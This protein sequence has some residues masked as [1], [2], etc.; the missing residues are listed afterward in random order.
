MGK[1]VELFKKGYKYCGKTLECIGVSSGQTIEKILENINTKVCTCC[2]KGLKYSENFKG[3]NVAEEPD[4]LDVNGGLSPYCSSDIT[5]TIVEPGTYH[6]IFQA[7]FNIAGMSV[8][9]IAF[10][11][12]GQLLYINNPE[13]RC[14]FVPSGVDP[15]IMLPITIRQDNIALAAGDVLS[16]CST[17]L[18]TSGNNG[19][20]AVYKD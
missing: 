14:Q 12:N 8:E 9:N 20:F 2:S 5:F 18:L 16:I 7:N 3:Y 11:V 1:I 10:A 6:A 19:I 13:I 17:A 15:T 4:I